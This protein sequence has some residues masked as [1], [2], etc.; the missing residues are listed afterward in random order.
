MTKGSESTQGS[1]ITH[2]LIPRKNGHVIWNKKSFICNHWIRWEL[3]VE[4]E[5]VYSCLL[6]FKAYK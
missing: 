4:M 1:Q 3:M 2:A 6:L 5:N